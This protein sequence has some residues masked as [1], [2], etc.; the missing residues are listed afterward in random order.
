MKAR[1]VLKILGV[2]Q[3][4]LFN[5]VK[6][7]KIKVNAKLSVHYNDYNEESVYALIGNKKQKKNR[8]IISY[9]RVSTQ[10]QKEQLKEQ[11]QR[12]YN[13][14]ISRGLTLDKQF[15]DIKSGMSS[16]RPQFEKLLQMVIKNEVEL[17]II[18][19]KDRLIRF[20]Y[21]IIE[22]IFKYF[23][24]KILVLNEILEN[25]TYEQEL[26]DDL[27]SIIHYFAMKSYSHR[28]VLNKIRKEI[29]TS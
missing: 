10:N 9:S 22:N 11:T 28:R 6:Q 5:Y 23:G 20:G 12:I 14:C 19:N 17:V 15:E 2:T 16:D 21:D 3:Q 13:S 26:T 18:E 29:E 25:K 27:I 8:L 4:T 1:E 24:T 7:G